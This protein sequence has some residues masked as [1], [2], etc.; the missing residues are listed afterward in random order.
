MIPAAG[1]DA[2]V[3][4]VFVCPHMSSLLLQWNAGRKKALSNTRL[5]LTVE[6]K[7]ENCYPVPSY[8]V[9]V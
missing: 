4:F 8:F 9:E 1:R 5:L 7:F 6:E 3:H 2:Y